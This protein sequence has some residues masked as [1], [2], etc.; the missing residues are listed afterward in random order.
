MV[1]PARS[2]GRTH[3][4]H[5]IRDVPETVFE[6][7]DDAIADAILDLLRQRRAQRAIHRAARLLLAGE[8]E[9]QIDE[10][11]FGHAIGQIARRL[12]AER[13][14]PAFD[15]PEDILR[16]IAELHDVP[17]IFD[18]DLIAEL[19]LQPIAD[20]DQRLAETGG[21][22]TIT[23]HADLDRVILALLRSNL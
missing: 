3:R 18:I 10:A 2:S 22:R 21:G 11:K 19:G 20:E 4:P 17:D 1:I 9:G 8:Q 16:A 15:Q 12:I 14:H 23:T 13:Q 6:P 5:T 7:A